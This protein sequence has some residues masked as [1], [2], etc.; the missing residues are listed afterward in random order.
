MKRMT[1]IALVAAILALSLG[2]AAFACTPNCP[3]KAASKGCTHGDTKMDAVQKAFGAL[4]ADL[5]Q[6][7]KGIPAADEAA[8]MK[9]HQANLKALFD[10][11]SACMK[12]C[13]AEA[14]AADK[15]GCKHHQAQQ[16]TFKALE[17][18]LA[19]M[20]KGIPA[21]DQAAFLKAHQDHLKS[22]IDT[23]N[24]CLRECKGQGAAKTEKT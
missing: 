20:E 10:S 6:M 17:T 22:L 5:A 23:H 14:A 11:R 1:Q 16:A 2:F 4:E 15:K 13:K 18:D 3:M 24:E 19:Q 7:Q 8:F 21:A 12:E 9:T